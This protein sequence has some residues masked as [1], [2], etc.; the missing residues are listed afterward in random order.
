MNNSINKRSVLKYIALFAIVFSFT[1]SPMIA[2]DIDFEVIGEKKEKYAEGDEIILKTIVFLTH[3]NCPEGIKKTRF[4]CNGL[5]ILR[6]TKWKETGSGEYTRK[7]KLKVTGSKN[8]KLTI[9]ATR[10]CDKEGGF[11]SMTFLSGPA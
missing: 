11:G 10:T 9:S 1:I 6:A 2:C 7:L 4:D 8:G 5:K 3:R